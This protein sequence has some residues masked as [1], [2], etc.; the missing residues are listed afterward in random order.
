VGLDIVFKDIGVDVLDERVEGEEYLELASDE[1]TIS[2]GTILTKEASNLA[3]VISEG[4]IGQVYPEILHFSIPQ[5]IFTRCFR[6]EGALAPEYC[7]QGIVKKNFTFKVTESQT[8]GHYTDQVAIQAN[9]NGYN[10]V[11]IRN[12]LVYALS[13]LSYFENDGLANVPFTIDYGHSLDS[14]FVQLHCKV[15]NLTIESITESLCE[16]KDITNPYFGLLDFGL[17]NTDLFEIY[18]LEKSS[19][20]VMTGVWIGNKSLDRGEQFPS[21]LIHGVEKFDENEN[22]EGRVATSRIDIFS[23]AGDIL[24]GNKGKGPNWFSKVD[25]DQVA[26]LILI[27]KRK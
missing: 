20:I 9:K 1:T 21:F 13:F 23:E 4:A 10:A 16:A 17:K 24:T 14:F 18:Y 3:D 12:F 6:N 8:F 11:S 25:L 22:R 5:K 15:D 19:Q 2:E 27:M 26:N 7:Y